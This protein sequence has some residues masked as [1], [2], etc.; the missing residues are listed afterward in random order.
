MVFQEHPLK[1]LYRLAA[2]WPYR[3]LMEWLPAGLEVLVN[4]IAGRA[5]KVVARGQAAHLRERLSEAFGAPD[6]LEGTVSEVFQTHFANQYV[7]FSFQKVTRDTLP[8]Y[9]TIEG[10][11]HLKSALELGKGVVVAHPHFALPQLPLH[12]LG[13]L[14]YAVNQVGG[15][16]PNIQFSAIGEKVAGIRESLESRIQANLHDATGFIRPALRALGRN[17]VLFTASDGTGSGNEMGR[18][19]VSTVLG[20][21]MSL[22]VFAVWAGLKT[23]ATVLPLVTWRDE[24][25]SSLYRA[26]FEAPLVL[27]GSA[28][29]DEALQAGVDQFAGHLSGWLRAHPGD[30]HFWDK[31]TTEQGGLLSS[32]PVGG[33]DE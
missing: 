33:P 18:R 5:A 7:V 24:S 15:G 8:S 14:G 3:W 17:E 21:E 9:L 12:A 30:W 1:D 6:D 20:R 13:V 10:F 29:D 26:R 2:W 22:P 25:G 31:W 27:E 16:R 4:R 19:L 11:E 23:G 28:K 32:D